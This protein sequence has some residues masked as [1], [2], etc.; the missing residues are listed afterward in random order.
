MEAGIGTQIFGPPAQQSSSSAP[1]VFTQDHLVATSLKLN[2]TEMR[3]LSILPCLEALADRVS[4][5]RF[6]SQMH[7]LLDP[8]SLLARQEHRVFRSLMNILNRIPLAVQAQCV[9]YSAE[10]TF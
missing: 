10:G 8:S 9:D 4:G 1:S 2:G 5:F 6:A 7:L 3:W